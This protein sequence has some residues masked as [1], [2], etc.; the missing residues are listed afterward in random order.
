MAA[1]FEFVFSQG[2]EPRPKVSFGPP[3][4]FGVC[5]DAEG[6]DV[7]VHT[8]VAGDLLMVNAFLPP[9]L[10]VLSILPL[11][12]AGPSLSASIIAGKYRF[13]PAFKLDRS[14]GQ[15]A[16]DVTL[17][18]TAL[19]VAVSRNGATLTKDIRPLIRELRLEAGSSPVVHAVLSLAPGATCKPSELLSILFPGKNFFDFIVTR[20]T[21]LIQRNGRLVDIQEEGA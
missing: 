7:A 20:N 13:A 17:K 4:P 12:K 3:L 6:F 2:F 15:K 9:D 10:R 21:C 1:G 16:V 5:G 18:A 19:P 8:P 11:K 14:E